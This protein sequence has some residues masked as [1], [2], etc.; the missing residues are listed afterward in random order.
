MTPSRNDTRNDT[1]PAAC[2]VCA[3]TF[4]PA[5]RQRYCTPACRQAAWRARHPSPKPAVTV[6]APTRRRDI[7]IYQCPSC[8]T[9]YLAQQ[10][11]HDC[12][13]PCRRLDYGGLCPHCDQP[14]TIQDITDQHPTTKIN[15]M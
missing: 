6:P 10:Y 11:C 5:R 15:K 3:T 9:R 1:G 4:T 2:P 8:D 14:I 12:H 7:T 13:Q